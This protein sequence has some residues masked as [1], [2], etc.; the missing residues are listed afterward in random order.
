MT[1]IRAA[2][3]RILASGPAADDG[4]HFHRRSDTPEPCYD[5]ACTIPRLKV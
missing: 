3:R 5:R 1:T 2:L 4:V